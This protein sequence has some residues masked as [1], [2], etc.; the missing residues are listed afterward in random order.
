M[1]ERE[2]RSKWSTVDPFADNNQLSKDGL[3]TIIEAR[4]NDGAKD[5]MREEKEAMAVSEGGKRAKHTRSQ[6]QVTTGLGNIAKAVISILDN[7][8]CTTAENEVEFQIQLLKVAFL[9]KAK[10]T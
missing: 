8:E 3:S 7:I 5:T 2:A 9:T 6:D 4:T 1:H 10:T